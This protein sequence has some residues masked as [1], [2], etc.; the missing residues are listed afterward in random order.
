MMQHSHLI[1]LWYNYIMN[2]ENAIKKFLEYIE[3]E[4]NYTKITIIDYQ[5]DL[6]L[7]ANYIKEKNTNY[8][9]LNKNDII[10][11]LKFLDNKKYSN[12]SIARFLSTLR[13]FYS[14]LVEIKLLEENIFKRI[15]NPKLEKKLPDYLN[16]MEVENLLS[17]FKEDTKEDIRNKCLVELLYSTGIRVSEA[18][19]IKIEDIDINNMTIRVFGKGRKERITYFG[20]T[21]KETLEKYLKVRKEFLKKGEINYLFINNIGGQL[22]RQ[23]IENIFNNISK[24]LNTSHKISPHTLRHTYATHLLNNNAD[25]RSVQELLGHENLSTT[26]IYTHV[27]NER[28]RQEYLKYHPNKNRQ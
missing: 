6:F 25:L 27:S 22:S 26:E 16:I 11:F 24:K 18:S 20:L 3:K 12:K 21:L 2:I 9:N 15:R 1:F 10:E 14:Y 17:E 19:N 8:L 13:S 4:L 28:L 7:F 5:N 23:S